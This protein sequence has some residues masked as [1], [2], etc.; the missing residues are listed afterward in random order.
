[1][2]FLDI[3]FLK[4]LKGDYK[5]YNHFIESGTGDGLSV[6]NV[7][8]EFTHVDTIEISE[9]HYNLCKN[10][11]KGNLINFHLGDSYK[12]FKVLLPT[13]KTNAIFY[14]DG[15]YSSGDTGRGE[16]DCPL[17]QEAE[18][19]CTYFKND[20][21]IIID[22][23][24]LFGRGPPNGLAEDWRDISKDKIIDTLKNRIT[25]VYHLPSRF[26]P[27]DRLILHIRRQYQLI[28]KNTIDGVLCYIYGGLGNQ[29][30]QAVA[31]YLINKSKG[32]NIYLLKN[33][34][35]KH[36]VNKLDYYDILLKDFG[37]EIEITHLNFMSFMNREYNVLSPITPYSNWNIELADNGTLLCGFYQYY[38]TI[39]PFEKDIREILLKRL[40]AYRQSLIDKMDFTNAIF[41]HVRRGDYVNN[42]YHLV[43]GIEYYKE[44]WDLFD[45][46]INYKVFLVSDDVDYFKSDPFFASTNFEIF[47]GSE[48]ETLALMSLCTSG[49][50]CANST[51]SWWGAFLGAYGCRNRVIV[52]K[53]WSKDNAFDLIPKEWTLL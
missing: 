49:A 40:T 33:T 23:Y 45:K 21:I 43:N 11:Y 8:A 52:P 13:I 19:I 3:E 6:F 35:C 16:R 51:F 30:F 36:N 37:K 42:R 27:F 14:L 5:S 46:S 50:V 20:A 41:I 34:D 39:A 22:N 4:K 18:E 26:S 25:D 10:K 12:I 15:H 9:K 2:P 32:L 17:I 38:P 53:K 7:C 31:G 44:A 47:K 48:I 28:P 29:I 24:R 1:M